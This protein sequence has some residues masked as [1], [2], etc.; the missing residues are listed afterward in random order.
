MTPSVS[1]PTPFDTLKPPAFTFL[2]LDEC[3][4]SV[5]DSQQ[6][7]LFKSRPLS[8]RREAAILSFRCL[9]VVANLTAGYSA[10]V[11]ADAHLHG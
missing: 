5:V 9:V 6:H 8:R 1:R 4:S 7:A 10:C 2:C 3:T 11:S